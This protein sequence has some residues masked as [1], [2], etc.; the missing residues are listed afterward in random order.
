MEAGPM[1]DLLEGRGHDERLG[2]AK[3]GQKYPR[4][5]VSGI[6]C[7]NASGNEAG[8]ESGTAD[9]SSTMETTS[10][11]PSSTPT[12]IFQ[13]ISPIGDTRLQNISLVE[14]G[15]LSVFAPHPTT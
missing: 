3:G 2:D 6:L 5:G 8:A 13:H 10:T 15:T 14:L 9:N 7:S 4:C 12:E 11:N 1:A